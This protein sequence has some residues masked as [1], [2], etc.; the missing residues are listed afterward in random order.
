MELI[1][2]GA[3]IEAL[4]AT[5]NA[6]ADKAHAVE[7]GLGR[8]T[9]SLD[10]VKARLAGLRAEIASV[11]A[12][13]DTLVTVAGIVLIVVLLYLALLHFVLFRASRGRARGGVAA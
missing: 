4:D 7:A 10:E 5:A 11:A 9:T 8:I 2:A 12:T 3:A 1:T 13:A 6:I